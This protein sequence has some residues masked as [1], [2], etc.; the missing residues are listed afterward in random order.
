MDELMENEAFYIGMLAGINIYQR[1]IIMAH[2]RKE[3]IKIG[4]SLYYLQ[5]GRERLEQVLG[6]ICK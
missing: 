1:K 3:H 2:E 6:E 5:D 4:D